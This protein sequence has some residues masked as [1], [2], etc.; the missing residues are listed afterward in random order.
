MKNVVTIN[1]HLIR[2]EIYPNRLITGSS[3]N[4][5]LKRAM[6]SYTC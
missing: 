1:C 6:N 2:E 4:K 5:N 3:K